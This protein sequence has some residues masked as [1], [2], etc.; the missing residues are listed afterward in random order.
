VGDHPLSQQPAHSWRYGYER[1]GEKRFQQLSAALLMNR[2]PDAHAFP[3]G[4]SDGGR[5]TVRGRLQCR[6]IYQVKWTNHR[7][8]DP[9]TW[10]TK[11]VQ[12][13]RENIKRLVAEG[14]RE[15]YL[16][17]PVAGTATPGTGTMDRLD[18]ALAQHSR[19][20]DIPM[21]CWWQA[22][23]DA[24]VD[25]APAELKWTYS[26]MLMGVDAFRCLLHGERIAERDEKLR[27]LLRPVT[28]AQRETDSAL[29]FQQVELGAHE[30]PDLFVDVEAR[31][32]STPLNTRGLTAR[33]LTA[34]QSLGGAAAYLLSTD[35]PFV[36]VHGAPGQ[37]KST[38][39]QLVCQVYRDLYLG[40]PTEAYGDLGSR[41]ADQ[42]RI[43]LRL[44]LRD[45]AVW[46]EGGDPFGGLDT[47]PA[48]RRRRRQV[49]LETFLAGLLEAVSGGRT[50]T[51]ETVQEIVTRFP[52]MLVLDGLDEVGNPASRDLVV[53][54]IEAFAG[55]LGGSTLGSRLVVTTRPSVSGLKEPSAD[56]FQT[57]ALQRL[58]PQLR[59]AY[60]R[61]WV[62]V[63]ALSAED[64]SDLQRIF[65]ERSAEPHIAQLADN[66]MQLTILLYLMRRRGESV[67]TART[68]LYQSYLETFLDR[69]AAKDARVLKHRG[70]L[71]EVTA[72]LGWVLQARAESLL[73]DDGM[74]TVELADLPLPVPRREGHVPCGGSVHRGDRPRVGPGEQE[75]GPVRV[76]RATAARVL[77]G[78]LPRRACR[79][80]GSPFRQ[81]PGSRGAGAPLLLGEHQPVLRRLQPPQRARRPQGGT[82]G[83]A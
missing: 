63:Q 8:Q 24:L 68:P 12:G 76:R 65:L 17:T 61:K 41:A 83:G 82:G 44:D 5:D 11:A 62:R 31:A 13:E 22:D 20:L 30:L 19:E 74:R 51:V 55:R 58:S 9:V 18:E 38:L 16:L 46:L 21:A 33:P 53:K 36:L 3:V 73:S 10:L 1:L 32:E 78:T 40:N 71:E 45:Y 25:S 48:P 56:R 49:S 29:K 80:G 70:A 6:I 64:S 7:V 81:V 66:P 69:E 79:R 15:Y 37:G 2:F 59:S 50:V 4:H 39:G 67:P 75:A 54:E 42:P 72:Y 47:A 35:R 52:V 26:D 27:S 34:D 14:A 57:I 23:L 43:A 77:R 28:A 60:L